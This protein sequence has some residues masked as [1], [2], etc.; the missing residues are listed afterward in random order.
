MSTQL[1]I[2]VTEHELV[3]PFERITFPNGTEVSFRE[4]DHSYWREI[5]P[6]AGG[7]FSGSGRMTGVST[8]CG[9][10]DFRPDGLLRWVERLTLEGVSRGF[11]GQR[12]PQDPHALRQLLQN[13][14]LRWEQIRDQ[15]GERGTN[16][17]ELFLKRL[18]AGQEIPDLGELPKEQRGYGQAVLKW[19][20][21][22]S[23]E[24]LHAEQVV[25]SHEHGF[26]GTLD[27]R[28]RISGAF[29]SGVV[30]VDA[31]TSGFLSAKMCAQPA[32]YD[33]GVISS[34]LG[35]QADH[36]M[37]LQLSEQGSY[38]E[39]WLGGVE[40]EHFLLALRVYRQE[41]E[42]KKMLRAAA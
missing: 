40:H 36:L 2:P 28:C 39:V 7:E 6:K 23:P 21:D 34:E 20:L 30:I 3:G 13:K 16:V 17:H 33:L 24:P 10:Y 25:A 14:E 26:A 22:R 38:N 27:L 4:S 31:K 35:D 29:H 8:L 18:A 42:F 9:P 5:K 19:W 12:V 1:A 11:S 32:G 37:I 41:A 15:A